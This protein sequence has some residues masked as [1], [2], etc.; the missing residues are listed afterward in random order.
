MQ[1]HSWLVVL[2]IINKK[3]ENERITNITNQD[4][5]GGNNNTVD[6]AT[7]GIPTAGQTGFNIHND[8][9]DKGNSGTGSA[10]GGGASPGSTGAGGSDAMGSF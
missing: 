2:L 3:K 8:A 10:N 4:T 9:Y 7:Y 5:Q 1:F 6:M